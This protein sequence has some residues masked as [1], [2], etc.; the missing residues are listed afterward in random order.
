MSMYCLFHTRSI[1]GD[2]NIDLN[3]SVKND[4]TSSIYMNSGCDNCNNNAF[5]SNLK[6][7]S[8]VILLLFLSMMSLIPF[9]YKCDIG[10]LPAALSHIWEAPL[11]SS[12]S[13]LS[14]YYLSWLENTYSQF[15]THCLLRCI[16][17]NFNEPIRLYI[18]KHL[19]QVW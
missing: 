15:C 12:T 16:V 18:T 9:V 4:F 2:L 6:L 13:F 14:D 10:S 1:A 17:I 3:I 7:E 19:N 5:F 11:V 8:Y